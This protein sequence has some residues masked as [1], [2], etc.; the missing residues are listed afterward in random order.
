M[1]EIFH[2]L[3]LAIN[4]IIVILSYIDYV[5]YIFYIDGGPKPKA[6]VTSIKSVIKFQN[7]RVL[8]INWID[9]A[10][11]LYYKL[12]CLNHECFPLL[13]SKKST[14]ANINVRKYCS[15]TI[16]FEMVG[17]CSKNFSTLIFAPE[18]N[19]PTLTLAS[20]TFTSM[21]NSVLHFQEGKDISLFI[22]NLYI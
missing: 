12:Y 4:F 16:F 9:T 8:Q 2:N 10:D 14:A 7:L 5:I 17:L 15:I 21:H 18:D 13:L 20:V 3:T 1:H 22:A 11:V 19:P 6:N